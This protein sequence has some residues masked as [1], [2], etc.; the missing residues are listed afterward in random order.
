M[1]DGGFIG[2][3][4]GFHRKLF[5]P[6]DMLASV[7]AQVPLRGAVHSFLVHDQ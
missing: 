6:V 7:N 3:N 1:A 2:G 5:A 4:Q